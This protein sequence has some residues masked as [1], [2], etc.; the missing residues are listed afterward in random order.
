MSEQTALDVDLI[1][2]VH[3]DA[4]PIERA[5]RSALAV[6]TASLRVTVVCHNIET[7]P[8]ER[9]LGDLCADPRVRLVQHRD[10]V[11]SPAGPFNAGLELATARYTSIM[12]SDDSLEAGAID[13]WLRRA[14]E[15]RADVVIAGLAHA[16]GRAVPT[17][18]VRLFREHNLD[19]VRDRLSYRTAPLGLVSRETFGHL[20]LTEGLRTGEDIAYGL[21]LW[22]HAR[23]IEFARS[24]PGYLVHA[25]ADERVT[26][27]FGPIE[28]DLEFVEGLLSSATL[29]GLGAKQRQAFLTKMVRGSLLPLVTNR[30]NTWHWSPQQNE[31][32]MIVAEQFLA[33]A[34]AR[35]GASPAEAFPSLSRA[36][37]RLFDAMLARD[38]NAETLVA[39][40]R[41]TRRRLR[42]A[43]LITPRLGHVLRAD[44]PLR[45]TAASV[46]LFTKG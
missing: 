24:G 44:A 29:R 36:E 15:T 11:K 13:S 41:A 31:A 25:D 32:L 6:S 45:F 20:R 37:A 28:D 5:V 43:S 33:A 34:G 10:A 38:S 7:E 39:A 8:I 46:A 9:R 22:A 23:R 12:G 3:S 27:A 1:I 42:L 4:R 16:G 18:P 14:D 26:T 17:P 35:E 40:A 19:M 21:E 2:A 30:L